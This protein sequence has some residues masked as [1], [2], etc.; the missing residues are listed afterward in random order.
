MHSCDSK[1]E[2][3]PLL[4]QEQTHNR[5]N[6]VPWIILA[7]G[8]LL[9]GVIVYF[10]RFQL[11][12]ALITYRYSANLISHKGFV[13]NAGEH[14]LGT[15]TP[16]A[17]LILAM[18]STPFG[19][20][21]IVQVATVVMP[22]FGLMSGLTAYFVLKDRCI[23]VAA[24]GT[25][26]CFLY[27]HLAMIRTGIG[28][29]ETPLVLLLMGLSLWALGREKYAAMGVFCGLL[30]LCRIDGAI[31]TSIIVLA[32]LLKSRRKIAI[33]I[34]TAF[35][36]V[37]PWIVFATIYFGTFLPNSMLAKAA[38][39]PGREHQLLNSQ[40]ILT[41]VLWY[42]KGTRYY[43]S[44]W[45]LPLWLG[46]FAV[47]TRRL[48]KESPHELWPIAIFPIFYTLVMYAGRA[49][50]FEWYLLPITYCCMILAGVGIVEI[51]QWIKRWLPVRTRIMVS[52]AL[53]G[54]VVV[55]YCSC[56]VPSIIRQMS[57]SQR[58]EDSARKGI[59]LWLRDNTPEDAAVAME[60]IGY[61]GYYSER[62][63]I[64]FAGLV[65]PKTVEFKKQT[66]MNG[67][68]FDSVLQFF[69]PDYIVLR[70]FEVDTNKH[71]NGGPLFLTHGK[72]QEFHQIYR[73]VKR[74][75]GVSNN[76]MSLSNLTVF[77]RVTDKRY[78]L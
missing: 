65:T 49:P 23:S 60:A 13:F 7:C 43:G 54:V 47:G 1:K 8:A 55:T 71:F 17:T 5:T 59:G 56:I 68:V 9:W 40:Y 78:K 44:M 6:A 11:E 76:P 26:M 31:W 14:V 35:I 30:M 77:K 2:E 58:R 18:L 20:R 10:T 4:T 27:M 74:Y 25:A 29:M 70:S 75:T 22:I 34:G 46:L 32:G 45:L 15:T 38:I 12:D 3:L 64:D 39:R 61:Q 73:E 42:V 19:P 53:I 67:E 24:A 69:K 51:F 16:L 63:V 52:A 57:I 28:G 48:F 41:N 50:R 72:E 62:K 36:V 37:L 66:A 21:S 33:S